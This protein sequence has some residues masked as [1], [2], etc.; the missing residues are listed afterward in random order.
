MI[1]KALHS[2]VAITATDSA[3]VRRI[4]INVS[5]GRQGLLV[6]AVYHLSG[7]DDVD[8]K[9]LL[10]SLLNTPLKLLDGEGI[11][12]TL[13]GIHRSV[14]SPG[15][16]TVQPERGGSWHNTSF[17]LTLLLS[18]P[19]PVRATHAQ[20]CIVVPDLLPQQLLSPSQSAKRGL[21]P[22]VE[23]GITDISSEFQMGGVM[24]APAD[25]SESSSDDQLQSI[26]V[27]AIA[28]NP[29]A[30]STE[31]RDVVFSPAVAEDLSP[32]D[33]SRV[34]KRIDT[35]FEWLSDQL[36]VPAWSRIV[37]ANHT[38][39]GRITTLPSGALVTNVALIKQL[40]SATMTVGLSSQTAV[41]L[42]SIWWGGGCQITGPWS[43][44]LTSAIAIAMGSLRLAEVGS[45]NG[46]EARLPALR[47]RTF[48]GRL[49]DANARL[50]GIFQ[51]ASSLM[52]ATAIYDAVRSD[53]S[54][55]SALQ[56]LTRANWG[57]RVPAHAVIDGL[58]K[59]GVEL[60]PHIVSEHPRIP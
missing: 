28:G 36:G 35:V 55:L 38:E 22:H 51:P 33:R 57:M 58:Q 19:S 53:Q 13:D 12:V 47:K 45:A 9:P 50:R 14:G 42:A 24:A 26:L 2:A 31:R 46:I 41:H 29:D 3:E 54:R 23:V 43:S 60:P 16:L 27:H 11:G 48:R 4:E 56:S 40:A 6:R 32:A 49:R 7:N 25:Q 10:L 15:L 39:L 20:S 18:E 5:Q 37:V 21:R 52:I 44:E 17:A 8:G 1:L 34:N 30:N 59:G